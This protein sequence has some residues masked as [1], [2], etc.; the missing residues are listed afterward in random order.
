MILR[1]ARRRTGICLEEDRNWV[2]TPQKFFR[3]TIAPAGRTTSCGFAGTLSSAKAIGAI[4]VGTASKAANAIAR[5]VPASGFNHAR[6]GNDFLSIG[7]E[8]SKFEIEA[9][10]VF[11]WAAIGCRNTDQSRHTSTIAL[12]S[13]GA[14]TASR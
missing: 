12:P 14:S 13:A 9:F 7:F 11:G 5:R 10:D 8:A 4:S 6:H 1:P 2:P 3:H